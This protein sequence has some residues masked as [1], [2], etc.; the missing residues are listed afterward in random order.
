M[1]YGCRIKRRM[2]I[3][4]TV[5]L[6]KCSWE[7]TM[8]YQNVEKLK[9]QYRGGM[10]KWFSSRWHYIE[11][12]I[13]KSYLDSWEISGNEQDYRFVKDFIDGL[14]V[15][16][17]IP[18]I[19]L[20]YF[21]ID[22]IRMASVLCTLY[23]REGGVKYKKTM[24]DLYH[25]LKEKYPR[26][27]S[28]NFW[29]KENYPDQVWLDGLYMG[30]PFYAEYIRDFEPVKDY[31]DMMRQFQNARKNIYDEKRKLYLHAV[32][33]SRKMFWCDPS[34][35]LSPNVWSRA[36]GWLVMALIDVLDLL[37]KENVKREV[38]SG[39]LKE[40]VDGMIPHQHG[41]GLWY[42][43]ADKEDTPD[44]YLET[45]GTAMMAYAVLKAVRLG[46]LSPDYKS[47]AVKAFEGIIKTYLTEKNG[48]MILGGICKS[49]GLGMHPELGV[50]RDGSFEYYAKGELI[51]E[52]NGHGVAP[53]LM[54]YNEIGLMK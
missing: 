23:R 47:F 4:E 12:I 17:I 54:A 13:L 7:Y 21:S 43:V 31:S 32:D 46:Y 15:D 20:S 38:L 1:E 9:E 10:D 42:Q 26:T 6:K 30:Q 40:A 35:G 11:A 48:E 34:T 22:Q 2:K 8:K 19:N 50:L 16:G 51:A 49:A 36:V 44:N 3:A 28:G 53:F 5:I 45:S 29:H 41:S 37:E 18:Q 25:Q 52:N 14:Y 33:E 24:D 27:V 39:L